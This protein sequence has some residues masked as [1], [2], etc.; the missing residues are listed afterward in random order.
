MSFTGVSMMAFLDPLQFCAN[1]V[2][3]AAGLVNAARGKRRH[4]ECDRNGGGDDKLVYT[5][6]RS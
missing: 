6:C 4:L 5:S 2:L 3:G 1:S